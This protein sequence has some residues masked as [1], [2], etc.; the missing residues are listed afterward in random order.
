LFHNT[1]FSF[2][3]RNHRQY[4]TT[5]SIV[6]IPNISNESI[7]SSDATKSTLI[8]AELQCGICLNNYEKVI[9]Q[10]CSFVFYH[11]CS[12]SCCHVDIHFVIVALL[13]GCDNVVHV[14]FVDRQHCDQFAILHCNKLS[15]IIA[16]CKQK[17]IIR[18]RTHSF[19]HS[20]ADVID[21]LMHR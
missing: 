6:T 1:I 14:L 17:V 20:Y 3:Y 19:R 4:L 13:N 2:S 10:I 9:T 11:D 5:M 8:S 18:I 16:D 7:V 15:M 21:Q 12:R